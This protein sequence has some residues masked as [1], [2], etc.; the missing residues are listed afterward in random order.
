MEKATLKIEDT[1]AA[2]YIVR[3][4][5]FRPFIHRSSTFNT[6]PT[7]NGIPFQNHIVLTQVAVN[8]SS[9]KR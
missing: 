1:S 3:L 7:A 5:A 4:L 9:L 8:F 2:F 6:T